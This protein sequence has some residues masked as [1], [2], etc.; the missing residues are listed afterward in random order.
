[1]N[2]KLSIKD[3]CDRYELSSVYV[4][5]MIQR[6]EIKTELVPLS[7]GSKTMKHLIAVEEIERWRASKGSNR[8]NRED[9]RSKFTLYANAE[10][11][12]AIMKLLEE[13]QIESIVV[14][15]NKVKEIQ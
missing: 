10:E 3:V 13:N 14:R 7:E 15:A 9:G 12:E 8:S 5:R 4:R 11:Y 1:M 2:E 6:G